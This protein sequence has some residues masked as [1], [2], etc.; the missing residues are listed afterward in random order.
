MLSL[1]RRSQFDYTY[2][3]LFPNY[4]DWNF[5]LTPQGLL[6]QR[7][8][9]AISYATLASVILGTFWARRGGNSLVGVLQRFMK[10]GLR[11]TLAAIGRGTGHL[12]QMIS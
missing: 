10:D 6:R 1:S 2:R 3:C 9:K 4:S 7:L 11:A 8:R 12:Q 5:E